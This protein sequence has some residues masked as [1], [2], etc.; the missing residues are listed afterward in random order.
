MHVTG[1][2]V[3]YPTTWPSVV[4]AVHDDHVTELVD[5]ALEEERED[6]AVVQELLQALIDI[7]EAY[8]QDMIGVELQR[9]EIG[10]ARAVIAKFNGAAA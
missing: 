7:T 6:G 5:E 8:A 3:S 10:A 1:G 2:Q 4:K 9:P